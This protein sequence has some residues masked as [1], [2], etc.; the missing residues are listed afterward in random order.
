MNKNSLCSM[1]DLSVDEI[2][3]ILNDARLFNSSYSDWQLP[4]KKCLVAN[5]FLSQAPERII[6]LKVQSCS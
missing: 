3:S 2:L 4:L 5:L 1:N 6:L